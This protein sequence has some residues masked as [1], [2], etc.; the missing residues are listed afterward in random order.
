MPIFYDG[1][2]GSGAGTSAPQ[3]PIFQQAI[4]AI[5]TNSSAGAANVTTSSSNA[6]RI[7]KALA[8]NR[9]ARAQPRPRWRRVIW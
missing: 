1:G 2:S 5:L 3:H 9:A 6:R 8:S 7:A 4:T